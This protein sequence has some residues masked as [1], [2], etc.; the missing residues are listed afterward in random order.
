MSTATHEVAR[1][2]LR[3]AGWL[4]AA[5]GALLAGLAFLALIDTTTGYVLIVIGFVIGVIGLICRGKAERIA[6]GDGR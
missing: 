3:A 5:S 2:R 4:G 1:L 6:R